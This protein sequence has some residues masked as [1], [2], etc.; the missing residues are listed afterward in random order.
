MHAHDVLPLASV[1]RQQMAIFLQRALPRIAGAQDLVPSQLTGTETTQNSIT[2]ASPGRPAARSSSRPTSF[3]A[4]V[5]DATGCPCTLFLYITTST[6]ESSEGTVV[7]IDSA[8][9]ESG[10]GTLTFAAP[11]A[12][13]VTINATALLEGGGEVYLY[14]DMSAISGAFG[15][16]GTDVASASCRT[17][18]RGR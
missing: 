4:E 18:Q 10:N 5:A 17:D 1:S 12:A 2:L 6:G 9:Y 15:S 16:Q 13:N 11:T 8:G 3:T 14:A 7:S